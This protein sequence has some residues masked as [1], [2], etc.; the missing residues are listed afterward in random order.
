[1]VERFNGTLMKAL[2]KLAVNFRRNWDEYLPAVVYA[3]RTRAHSTIGIS[4]FELLYGTSPSTHEKDLLLQLR[5]RPGHERL[6]FH[7]CREPEQEAV[8]PSVSFETNNKFR[9]EIGS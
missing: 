2:K 5:R 1:M 7:Q 6:Y 8:S 9:L 3:Y 4:P